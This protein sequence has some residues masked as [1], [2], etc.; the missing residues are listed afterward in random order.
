M[1]IIFGN[2]DFGKSKIQSRFGVC[3]QCNS[4]TRL[5]SYNTVRFFT[6]YGIP[7]IPLGRKRVVN[8]CLTC[9]TIADIG[10]RKYKRLRKEERA[11]AFQKLKAEP[12]NPERAIEALGAFMFHGD[13]KNVEVLAPALAKKHVDNDKVQVACGMAYECLGK[14]AEAEASFYRALEVREISANREAL[15]LN[16]IFQVKPDEA[17]PFLEHIVREGKKEKTGKLYLLIE[18]YRD[19]GEHEKAIE[20]LN[21]IETIDPAKKK[22][23]NHLRLRRSSTA[24]LEDHGKIASPILHMPRGIEELPSMGVPAWVP[25]LVPAALVLVFIV[26]Y[27]GAA[28]SMGTAREMWLVNGTG[29]AYSVEIAGQ[30]FNNPP[31]AARKVELPEGELTMHLKN[32]PFPMEPEVVTVKT[33]FFT[34]PFTSPILVLN[35]DRLALL[36]KEE[37]VYSES[38]VDTFENPFAIHHGKFF[39]NF[40]G[41]DFPFQEFPEGIRVSSS[42]DRVY[43][44]RVYNFLPSAPDELVAVVSNWIEPEEQMHYF[45]RCLLFEPR[46][47]HALYALYGLSVALQLDPDFLILHLKQGLG[48]RPILVDWHRMYQTAMDRIDPDHDLTGEYNALVKAEPENRHLKYLLGRVSADPEEAMCL[49]RE[50][51]EGAEPNGYG[52]G[53]MAYQ[54]L[55]S[56]RFQEALDLSRKAIAALPNRMELTLILD[57][58]LLALKKYD[59]LLERLR[60]VKRERPYEG[61]IVGMEI[62][63]LVLLGHDQEAADVSNAFIKMIQDE[64]AGNET[65]GWKSYFDSVV[66][67]IN[68]DRKKYRQAMRNSFNPFAPFQA[69]LLDGRIDSA[70]ALL[71]DHAESVYTDYLLV[72]CL[73]SEEKRSDAAGTMLARAIELLETGEREERKAADMLKG[74]TAAVR[75]HLVELN[76]L[77]PQKTIL[78]TSLGLLMPELKSHCFAIARQHNF[79]P[80][81]PKYLLDRIIR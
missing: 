13:F 47:N 9:S 72:Y 44:T 70:V 67:Y 22:D 43:R 20:V 5:V 76:L 75:D 34:R 26:W 53:A 25:G 18:A 81:F 3:N 78:A 64:G 51:E 38:N 39:Y 48:K 23:K 8:A 69:A 62:K 59:E 15:A 1:I 79:D 12:D 77:P 17:R 2:K 10:L 58:S 80:Q 37:T 7:L 21:Q 33:S 55:C 4:Y 74:N 16:L 52:Y 40:S 50:S 42:A 56:G 31:Y 30:A 57:T 71:Q 32:T 27:L 61:Q 19:Q 11:S 68:G 60:E 36:I 46:N 73:A 54:N 24:A 49:Y 35:P 6:V 28:F 29:T 14:P 63:Y 45:S 65:E 41:I 66:H